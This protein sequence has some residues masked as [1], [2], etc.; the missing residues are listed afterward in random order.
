MKKILAGVLAAAS[1][2][3]MTVTASATT[4]D[5]TKAGD[6]T[7]TVTAKAP[8]VVLKLKMPAKLEAVLNPFGADIKLDKAETPTTT[9]AGIASVAY[10]VTNKSLDYGV[11][12]SGTAITTITTT[13]IKE[14]KTANWAVTTTAVVDDGSKKSAQMALVAVKDVAALKAAGAA[15]PTE[16]K[17]YDGTDG[18]LVMDST[19]AANTTKKTVAG[20]TDQAKFAFVPAAT[21]DVE[22]QKI[23][24]GFVGALASGTKNDVEITWY[25]DDAINVNLVIKVTAGPKEFPSGS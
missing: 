7:Y 21:A 16:S 9:D 8:A 20:Q 2:M 22:E 3:A 11:Y 4:K 15:V 12:L 10:D 1:V 19:A 17:A 6:V 18:A 14:D 5:V 23:V 25:D 13:D 24:L